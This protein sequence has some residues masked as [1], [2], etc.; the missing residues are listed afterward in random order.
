MGAGFGRIEAPIFN[1][2]GG[3]ARDRDP[4]GPKPDRGRGSVRARKR[5]NRARSGAAGGTKSHLP[6]KRIMGRFPWLSG[7][8]GSFTGAGLGVHDFT[9]RHLKKFRG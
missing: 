9:S 2:H 4:H 7:V 6:G 5:P 8:I 1:P 3:A